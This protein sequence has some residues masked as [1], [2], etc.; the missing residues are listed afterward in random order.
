MYFDM[1]YVFISGSPSYMN[2]RVLIL[3]YPIQ[4]RDHAHY[5][6]SMDSAFKVNVLKKF[7]NNQAT[8][9]GRKS[10]PV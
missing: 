2:Y 6:A 8:K 10:D 3:F 7:S 4:T 9:Q 1:F 5:K